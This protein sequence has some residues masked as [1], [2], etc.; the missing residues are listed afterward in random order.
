MVV[1][2]WGFMKDKRIYIKQ[3]IGGLYALKIEQTKLMLRRIVR[4]TFSL[5][6]KSQRP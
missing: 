4:Y 3:N 5:Y 6:I 2:F 1:L